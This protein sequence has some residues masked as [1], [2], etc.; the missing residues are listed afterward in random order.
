MAILGPK[1]PYSKS[2]IILACAAQLAT[3]IAFLGVFIYIC[4]RQ[5]HKAMKYNSLE[6]NRTNELGKILS[7]ENIQLNLQVLLDIVHGDP[8]N[9]EE[10]DIPELE[11]MLHTEKADQVFKMAMTT[12]IRQS[13]TGCSSETRF[14]FLRR[15]ITELERGIREKHKGS[16]GD[17]TQNS[18][19]DTN[20]D[21][22]QKVE[23]IQRS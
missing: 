13:L 11:E 19:K 14:V 12:I 22:I 8:F 2:L 20:E 9:N 18:L 15:C 10:L 17:A 4:A 21:Q 5:M 7:E 16:S 6:W 1:C 3:S 23:S